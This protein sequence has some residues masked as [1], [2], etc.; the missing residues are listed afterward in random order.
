MLQV[1]IIGQ[2][3]CGRPIDSWLNSAMDY[4]FF[5]LSFS[6][7][8]QFLHG[9]LIVTKEREESDILIF[10]PITNNFLRLRNLE[11]NLPDQKRSKEFFLHV[12]V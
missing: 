12:R 10:P 2:E 5:S 3:S 1:E 4:T 8:L 7:F 11:I 6:H 9:K